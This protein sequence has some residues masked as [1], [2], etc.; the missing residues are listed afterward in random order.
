MIYVTS[1]IPLIINCVPVT[2]FASLKHSCFQ[3]A[4]KGRATLLL[5]SLVP[6][7]LGLLAFI[8]VTSL[9]RELR[10]LQNCSLFSLQDQHYFPNHKRWPTTLSTI[11]RNF[12]T[13]ESSISDILLLDTPLPECPAYWLSHHHFSNTTFNCLLSFTSYLLE[14]LGEIVV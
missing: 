1:V 14:L 3:R 9:D 10:S 6:G 13:S 2:V 8:Q 11:P 4:A 7:S 12:L 5:K